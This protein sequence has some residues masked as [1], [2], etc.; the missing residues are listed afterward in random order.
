MG[1]LTGGRST[2]GP[3]CVLSPISPGPQMGHNDGHH[4][5][6]EGRPVPRRDQI[7]GLRATEPHGCKQGVVGSNPIV[8]TRVTRP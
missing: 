6:L 8:S 1:R 4:E 5:S 7:S 3:L 2:G